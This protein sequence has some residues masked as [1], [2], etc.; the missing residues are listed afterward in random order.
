MQDHDPIPAFKQQLG[1]E[2]AG[3][4]RDWKSRDVAAYLGT[5]RSR[6]AEL[7]RG[8]LDRFSLEKLIRLLVR[9]GK[10][11]EL[12]V[13]PRTRATAQRAPRPTEAG[14]TGVSGIEREPGQS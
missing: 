5:D 6:I 13:S 2:L 12:I 7:R 14:A 11:V 4:I 9:A 1:D 8:E 3:F 10:R